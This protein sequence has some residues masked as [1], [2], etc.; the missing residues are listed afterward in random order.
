MW[1]TIAPIEYEYYQQVTLRLVDY[2]LIQI[3]LLINQP[4]MLVVNENLME[5][6]KREQPVDEKPVKVLFSQ[7]EEVILKLL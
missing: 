1:V 5:Q 2:L 3:T 7:Y 4:E 6:L